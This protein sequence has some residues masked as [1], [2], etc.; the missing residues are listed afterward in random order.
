M[1]RTTTVLSSTAVSGTNAYTSSVTTML[2]DIYNVGY[3]CNIVSGTPN[4]EFTFE[5]SN[6]NTN[7][8]DLGVD[9]AATVTAGVFTDGGTSFLASLNELP[10][11]FVRAKYTNSSGTGNVSITCLARQI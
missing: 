7:W 2:P 10:F 1:E 5:A 6:D 8:V 9:P 3:Q 11:E 4:G